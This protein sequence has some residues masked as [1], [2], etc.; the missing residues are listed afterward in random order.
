MQIMI[1]SDHF[2]NTESRR[3]STLLKLTLIAKDTFTKDCCDRE[4]ISW[5]A[6]PEHGLPGEPVLQMPIEAV[7]ARFGNVES[8]SSELQFLSD[9]AS[10]LRAHETHA[11]ARQ[12]GFTPIH[13][14]VCSPQ[15][16]GMAESLVNTFNATTYSNGSQFYREDAVAIA[17]RFYPFQRS[18][19]AFGIKN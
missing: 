3:R 15:S 7:E 19:S 4:I 17:K 16:N 6:W 14:P 18:A 12:L 1:F 11:V 8:C 9:H 5:R 10:A 2:K 13:M